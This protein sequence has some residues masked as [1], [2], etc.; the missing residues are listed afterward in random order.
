MTDSCEAS[1]LQ[2]EAD[3]CVED[4]WALNGPK[5]SGPEDEWTFNDEG[6]VLGGVHISPKGIEGDT[7]SITSD[8]IYV[9]GGEH[10]VYVGPEG[11]YVQGA[12]TEYSRVSLRHL[13]DPAG[14]R[15]GHPHQLDR[16][17][18][19]RPGL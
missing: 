12:E 10:E 2:E 13:G 11:V 1:M 6:I 4:E 17:Q 18:C 7:F 9:T 16:G 19:G 14:K 8:G 5:T 3:Y 15:G